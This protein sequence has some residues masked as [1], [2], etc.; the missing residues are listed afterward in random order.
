MKWQITL[1]VFLVLAPSLIASAAGHTKGTRRS[2][3]HIRV[4]ER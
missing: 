3:A 1:I 4:Q 2:A